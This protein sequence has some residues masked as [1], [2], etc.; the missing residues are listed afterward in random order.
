MPGPNGAVQFAILD[1]LLYGTARAF[2]YLGFRGQDMLD[3]IGEGIIQ[4]GVSERYFEKSNDPHQFVGNV[5]KFF[6]ENGYLTDVSV[7]QDG[8]TLEIGMGNW[9][10][11]PLMRKLRNSN[12]YLLTCPVCM[13][14]NAITK[15]AGGVSERMWETLAPDGRFTMKVRIVPGKQH[16]ERSVIPAL[17]ANLK[18]AN[19]GD[20]LNQTLGA[21]AFESIAYGLAYGFEFLGAQAQLLLDNIGPG[22]IQFMQ[23]ES[24]LTFPSELEDALNV[25]AKFMSKGGLAN[26][27]D[28]EVSKLGITVTFENSRYLPVLRRLLREEKELVSC[29]FILPARSLIKRQGLEVRGMKWQIADSNVRLDMRTIDSRQDEFNE[30]VVSKAMD[31]L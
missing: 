31:Q 28:V 24:N 4:Y 14:N 3:R 8:S 6:V 16:V 25:L 13:A 18:A 9:K 23:D 27:I 17:P 26:T 1:P 2:D 22:M 10:F 19:F 20:A 7:K 15:S 5:V 30:E 29:P 11:L 12:S 21:R